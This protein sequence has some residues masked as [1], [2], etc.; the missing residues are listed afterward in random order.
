LKNH[1][2]RLSSAEYPRWGGGG[3]AISGSG[4]NLAIC[5]NIV[6]VPNPKQAYA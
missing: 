3:G 2:F 5:P 1:H 4:D 6:V